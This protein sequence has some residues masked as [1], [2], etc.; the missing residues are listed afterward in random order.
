MRINKFLAAHTTLSRR[1]AD[2]AIAEGRVLLNGRM[3]GPGDAVGADDTVILDNQPITPDVKRQTIMFNKPVGYVCSRDGQGSNTVYDILPAEYQHLNLV[4]R[5]DKNSSGLLLLTNDGDLANEL[6]HPRYGKAKVYEIRLNN[7]LAPL[8]QQMI[9][10][11]GVQLSDGPSQLA[12]EKLDAQGLQWRIRMR[13]GR[14]RQIRR[15]FD[16]LGYSVK[17]L[18]RTTFGE[19]SLDGLKSGEIRPV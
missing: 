3:P 12:L 13:E 6:T 15:T 5:L 19:Y 14:N 7:P 17:Y 1:G 2:A 8:H 10:D 16:A 18:H 9:S 4:G 11:I